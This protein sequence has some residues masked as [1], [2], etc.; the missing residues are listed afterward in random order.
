MAVILKENELPE[1]LQN[2]IKNEE[3]RCHLLF[4]GPP[5]SGKTTAAQ[6]YATSWKIN[7]QVRKPTF[8]KQ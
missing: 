1:I 6:S 2:M 7:K 4:L 5:G 8:F 3:A